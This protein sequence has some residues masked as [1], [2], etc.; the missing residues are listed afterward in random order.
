MK[1][2]TAAKPPTTGRIILTD[3]D[4]RRIRGIRI[5]DPWSNTDALADITVSREGIETVEPSSEGPSGLWLIP[6]VTDMHVHLRV[7]GGEA[8]ETLETGLR[9]AAAGGVT[10]VGMMP[11]TTPPLDTPDAVRKLLLQAASAGRV[12][13][14]PV[15]CA[16][17]GRAGSVPVDLEGF[18]EMGITAFSDDGDPVGSDEVL[19]EIFQRISRFSGTLIEHPEV[20]ALSSGGA[21]NQGEASRL[22]GAGGIPESAEYEDVQRCIEVLERSGTAARLHL[23]HLSSPRSIELAAEAASR[24]LSVT[25]DVTP[26][27][28]ALNETEIIERGAVAKMNPPL[29]CEDSRKRLAALAAGGKVTAV[30]SDH[31]PHPAERKE[32][33]LQ[34]AAFGITGLETI[35]PLTVDELV[36]R[37]GME[38]LEAVRLITSNP[39]RILG[40]PD[41]PLVPGVRRS[42]VLFDPDALWHYSRS[43]SLS[44]NS[45]F[46]GKT[47][48]GR[49]LQV[50][51]G[52]LIFRE[53]IF[54]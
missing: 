11:N 42:M 16:T 19:M 13:V 35:L 10:A 14:R 46:L 33:P 12:T 27:H 44:R 50:W 29:R 4:T 53:G 43:F 49:I 54:V 47:L 37:E 2:P 3:S 22:T 45:P 15:P 40:L 38:P 21:V 32:L 34:Q 51:A 6:G 8:A 48:R 52:S 28:L 25:C 36:F 17:V 1:H 9:A 26:H 39:A 30:A 41:G 23:T 24:G 20:K 7:P 18:A 5:L 31:A